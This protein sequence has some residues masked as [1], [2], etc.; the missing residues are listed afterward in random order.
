M[1]NGILC[2]YI[3][4]TEIVIDDGF[5]HFMTVKF[6]ENESESHSVRS[7]F[8]SPHG[9]YS[10]WIS[11]GQNTGVGS[12]SLPQRIFP[13]Q[14]SNPGLPHCRGI[15][16]QLSHKESLLNSMDHSKVTMLSYCTTRW[17]WL[18]C[19]WIYI[20]IYNYHWSSFSVLYN[21]ITEARFKFVLNTYFSFLHLSKTY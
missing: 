1:T 9:Q 11:P 4:G 12:F 14:G 15:L 6:H 20:H 18:L 2:Q 21:V 17:P 3:C 13:T 10:P 8:L 19:S 7:N 5:I 16:Y